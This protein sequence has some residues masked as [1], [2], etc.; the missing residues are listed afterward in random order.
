[1]VESCLQLVDQNLLCWSMMIKS[2]MA[3]EELCGMIVTALDLRERG[4][5][6]SPGSLPA[7]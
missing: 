5:G 3:E 7:L 4:L 6:L 2:Q 1:M